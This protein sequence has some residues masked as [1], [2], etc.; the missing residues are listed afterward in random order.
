MDASRLE[1]HVP[2]HHSYR[3]SPVILIFIGLVGGGV[4]FFGVMAWYFTRVDPGGGP[5]GSQGHA[6]KLPSAGDGN[7]K[8]GGEGGG[9]GGEGGGERESLRVARFTIDGSPLQPYF[10]LFHKTIFGG[11]SHVDDRYV[12]WPGGRPRTGCPIP[13]DLYPY[14]QRI[15][16]RRHLSPGPG[17]AH[18]QGTGTDHG[19]LAGR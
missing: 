17:H 14:S 3:P 15:P 16:A 4:L 11:S 10:V 12:N 2:E 19:L 7:G 13:G 8:G 5:S 9:G 18:A 1:T 6:M